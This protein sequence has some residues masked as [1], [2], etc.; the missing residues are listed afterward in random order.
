VLWDILSHIADMNIKL[1]RQ[2]FARRLAALAC[3]D[4]MSHFDRMTADEFKRLREALGVNQTDLAN[5]LGV[6]RRT[7]GRW[8]TGVSPVPRHVGAL[9]RIAV[10]S[11]EARRDLGLPKVS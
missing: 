8:E 9:L 1:E 11:P 10:G 4:R 6:T 5:A 7:L 2:R 3:A